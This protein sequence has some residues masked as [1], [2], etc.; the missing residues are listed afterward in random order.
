MDRREAARAY[1]DTPRL[2]VLDPPDEP[3]YNPADDLAELK[4]MWEERLRSDTVG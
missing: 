1:K 4:A 2:D 3:G